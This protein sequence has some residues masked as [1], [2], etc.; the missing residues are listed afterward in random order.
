M[1]VLIAY[2]DKVGIYIGTDSAAGAGGCLQKD[3]GPKFDT[4]NGMVV[5]AVGFRIYLKVLLSE[6]DFNGTNLSK[7]LVES[8]AKRFIGKIS[9]MKVESPELKEYLTWPFF[10][11]ANKN[12]LFRFSLGGGV[13]EIKDGFETY[14]CG[15]EVAT[16]A[17]LGGKYCGEK[18]GHTLVDNAVTACIKSAEGCSGNSHIFNVNRDLK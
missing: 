15:H 3:C 7:A 2:K 11:I 4:R 12:K 18:C 9:K 6:I 13:D 1:S 14:G 10:V 5:S 17:M 16:G 8:L